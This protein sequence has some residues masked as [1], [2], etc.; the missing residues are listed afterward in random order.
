MIA[1]CFDCGRTVRGCKPIVKII[2]K[3]WQE[4]KT[5][6]KW[7][8]KFVCRSCANNSKDLFEVNK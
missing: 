1:K 6:K 8:G 4:K 7:L 3:S 2:G 5:I